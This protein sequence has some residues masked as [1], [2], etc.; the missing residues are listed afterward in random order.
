MR[1]CGTTI[2]IGWSQR[3]LRDH[4]NREGRFRWAGLGRASHGRGAFSIILS[5]GRR[6]R[7]PAAQSTPGPLRSR[8]DPLRAQSG[9]RTGQG[10]GRG[11]KRPARSRRVRRPPHSEGRV[12]ESVLCRSRRR[13]PPRPP[14]RPTPAEPL[15]ARARR[16]AARV[17]VPARVAWRRVA[18]SPARRPGPDSGGDRPRL[19][20]PPP[21]RRPGPVAGRPPPPRPPS[22]ATGAESGG[23]E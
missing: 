5:A 13:R 17:R 12:P 6:G 11:A 14:V 18:A 1:S 20:R 16:A 19:A 23:A 22:P 9:R 21:P 7:R 2:G 10:A 3:D 4:R 15:S 8:V